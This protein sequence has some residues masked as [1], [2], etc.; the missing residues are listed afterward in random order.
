MPESG[1]P[2]IDVFPWKIGEAVE[3]VEGEYPPSEA[4]PD[5]MRAADEAATIRVYGEWP[6]EESLSSEAKAC[7]SD[8]AFVAANFDKSLI[9]NGK[10]VKENPIYIGGY[11]VEKYKA[12]IS[13]TIIDKRELRYIIGQ[14]D[15]LVES[16]NN[17]SPEVVTTAPAPTEKKVVPEP[18]VG[19]EQQFNRDAIS[20]G[21]IVALAHS[22]PFGQVK[23]PQK[24]PAPVRSE[25]PE[26]DEAQPLG[27][28]QLFAIIE[29]R[30]TRS[31]VEAKPPTYTDIIKDNLVAEGLVKSDDALKDLVLVIMD[32]ILTS[33]RRDPSDQAA[34]HQ[35]ISSVQGDV[36]I[37]EEDIEKL[38]GFKDGLLKRK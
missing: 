16:I 6:G 5:F 29:G 35:L 28:R 14:I 4:N 25:P 26:V 9:N 17:A 27:K 33:F 8:I 37:D 18:V 15:A 7:L 20:P 30:R 34:I 21:T 2:P 1:T 23:P 38:N 3:A 24:D 11:L 12:I 19:P 22:T 13:E 36:A 10:G 31:A 32:K